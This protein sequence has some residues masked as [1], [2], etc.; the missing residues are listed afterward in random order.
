MPHWRILERLS[1]WKM[2][3]RNPKVIC[4]KM[5]SFLLF[6]LHWGTHKEWHTPLCIIVWTKFNIYSKTKTGKKIHTHTLELHISAP[7][8]LESVPLTL[9]QLQFFL[10]FP[11]TIYSLKK[12]G[13]LY[14]RFY[15]VWVFWVSSSS[16]VEHV[17][18]NLPV[19]LTITEWQPFTSYY[20][21]LELEYVQ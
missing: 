8:N 6:L 5:S 13:H 20:D 1:T 7:E 4:H 17:L 9:W 18:L 3:A 15:I 11:L 21:Y 12:L 10:P 14:H 2:V 16:V 19:N